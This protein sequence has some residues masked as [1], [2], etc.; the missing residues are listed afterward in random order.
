MITTLINNQNLKSICSMGSGYT[1]KSWS[2]SIS[3]SNSKSYSSYIPWSKSKS[4]VNPRGSSYY[5]DFSY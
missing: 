1:S 2:D 4:R 5:R 3:G